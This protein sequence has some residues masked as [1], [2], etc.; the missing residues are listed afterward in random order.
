MISSDL[1]EVLAL[2]D[3]ILVMSQGH[4]AGELARTAA[5]EERIIH[6]ASGALAAP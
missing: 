2:A 5:T 4:L 1:T 6:L 3:R